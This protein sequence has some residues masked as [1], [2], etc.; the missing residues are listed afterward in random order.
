MNSRLE[1]RVLVIRS[2][3]G[4][5][6][7]G[8]ALDS[9]KVQERNMLKILSLAVIAAGVTFGAAAAQADASWCTDAHMKKMDDMLAK[10]TDATAKE[11]AAGHLAQ[12]KEAMKGGDTAAC[13]A[14]M[15]Q[16]HKAMG[17]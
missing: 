16:V 6:L 15:E 14:Q 2:T 17:M 3:T 8:P 10:M 12:S 13:I 5:A 7:N 4:L 11:A 1:R 9:Q